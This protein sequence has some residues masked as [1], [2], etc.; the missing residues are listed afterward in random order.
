MKH[1]GNFLV[2]LRILTQFLLIFKMIDLVGKF[3]PQFLVFLFKKL[4]I[5]E[6]IGWIF[7]IFEV[8]NLQN[9]CEMIR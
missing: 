4:K 3:A 9:V 2:F 1:G 7:F 8:V 5:R 6:K